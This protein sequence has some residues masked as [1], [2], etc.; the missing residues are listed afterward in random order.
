M[1]VDCAILSLALASSVLTATPSKAEPESPIVQQSRAAPAKRHEQRPNVLIWMLD[2]VGFAQISSF[3]G[4]VQTPNIDR[5]AQAG[6]RYSNYRTAPICSASRAA[7]LSGRMPH[8]VHIG[9]HAAAA[10]DHP[11]HDARIP[12]SA[13]SF[14]MGR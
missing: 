9:G 6:L 8:S 11:G 5:V 2:D 13:G 14:Q 4:L 10:R 12:A 3:G 1:R 7:I